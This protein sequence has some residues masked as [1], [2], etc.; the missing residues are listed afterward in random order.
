MSIEQELQQRSGSK[1]E[2]CDAPDSFNVYAVDL[3]SD[4]TATQCILLCDVCHGQLKDPESIDANHWRCLNTS[5]WSTVR[6]VQ[7]I[8]WRM[9]HLSL[10]HI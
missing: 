5:M 6:P 4:G 7:V 1:C 8:V 2:L 10:I 9:L 3:E